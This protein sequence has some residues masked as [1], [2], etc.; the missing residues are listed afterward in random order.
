MDYLTTEYSIVPTGDNP[1][2]YAEYIDV[3]GERLD[4]VLE[5]II[6]VQSTASED[7][8]SLDERVT[9]LEQGGGSG[10]NYPP[11]SGIPESDLSA[12]VK[13]K[14]NRDLG[15]QCLYELDGTTLNITTLGSGL[16]TQC[17]F[18]VDGDTLAISTI[19]GD[20]NA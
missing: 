7:I 14:L 12:E 2:T 4:A 3:S 5:A 17:Y 19:G 20:R 18:V 11:E 10:G 8:N 6:Q 16:G 13:Q 1:V 15:T 9:K